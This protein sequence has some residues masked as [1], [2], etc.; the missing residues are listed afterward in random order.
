MVAT[1]K[2]LTVSYG[3][4]S[5]TLEGFDDSF[6]MMKAVAEY[7][8]D[9]S[10]DDRYF[11]AEPPKLD[12]DALAQAASRNSTQAISARKE[13]DTIVLSPKDTS[14][15]TAPSS[16]LRPASSLAERIARI[17]AVAKQA[18]LEERLAEPE[19][20]SSEH[21][22]SHATP[23]AGNTIEDAFYEDEEDISD[24]VSHAE[25]LPVT[26]SALADPSDA[27]EQDEPD[28]EDE[29][30]QDATEQTTDASEVVSV[31]E[32]PVA[33]LEPAE[34][35]TQI[36]P[37]TIDDI[38]E[39]VTL[40]ETAPAD[41]Q[42]QHIPEQADT[43][44][45][46][47]EP[48][49]LAVETSESASADATTE[50]EQADFSSDAPDAAALDATD[51]DQP[52]EMLV[53]DEVEPEME[54]LVLTPADAVTQSDQPAEP[55]KPRVHVIKVDTSQVETNAQSAHDDLNA[56]QAADL[57]QALG[58]AFED[59]LEDKS[60]AAEVTDEVSPELNDAVFEDDDFETSL[61]A[62]LADDDTVDDT[63]V[64]PLDT[65]EDVSEEI[66][67]NVETIDKAQVTPRRVS[68]ASQNQDVNADQDMDRLVETTNE[69]MSKPDSS[70]RRN[71]L[72]HLRAAV[73]ATLSDVSIR[74]E[75]EEKDPQ[76]YRSDLEQVVRPRRPNTRVLRSEIN[77]EIQQTPLRLVAEQ[78]VDIA[79]E[80]NVKSTSISPEDYATFD[81]YAEAVGAFSLEDK[82]EACASYLQFVLG[83]AAFSRPMLMNTVKKGAPE[84]FS[85]EAGLKRFGALIREGKIKR[86]EDGKFV[87]SQEIGYQPT[88]L[89][90]G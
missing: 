4:F 79:P 90:A 14:A 46:E 38:A 88:D 85:R 52:Q 78:R 50:L 27:I 66:Q 82:I 47:A 1:N 6:E 23:E 33:E 10:A 17:R 74:G 65:A 11:G 54:P 30:P 21:M 68:E 70:R 87:A 51:Q 16:D 77:E 45:L 25:I 3:T 64:T 43:I 41:P 59:T 13:G 40:E 2:V 28:Y 15:Q 60:P 35:S 61:A 76:A 55:R 56:Q 69:Q 12:Q 72:A 29:T 9:L 71:A 37:E 24:E 81:E 19:A 67:Q 39:S 89:M 86:T 84:E 44:S 36:T 83:E 53:Q 7:F 8:R 31:E 42:A 73:A 62:A 20:S 57:E 75:K 58:G 63:E 18:E 48:D 80:T 32:T 49:T 5:C 22:Q 26:A 34:T